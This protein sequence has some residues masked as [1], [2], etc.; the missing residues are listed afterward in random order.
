[1]EG[2][3]AGTPP[4]EGLRHLIHR[5]ATIDKGKRDR[6]VMI[7][8]V[9]RAFFEATASRLVCCELPEGYPGNENLD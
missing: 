4:L 8:D 6:C 5:A 2:L 7:N 9:S 1:M 3:F